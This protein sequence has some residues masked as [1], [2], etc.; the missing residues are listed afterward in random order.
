MEKEPSPATPEDDVS[1]FKKRKHTNLSASINDLQSPEYRVLE[2]A[3]TIKDLSE[4]TLNLSNSSF[5]L[6]SISNNFLCESMD[7]IFWIL[8]TK[9]SEVELKKNKMQVFYLVDYTW[10]YQIKS[11]LEQEQE[12]N[13][14]NLPSE[15]SSAKDYNSNKLNFFKEIKIH[16]TI[17]IL[18]SL[19]SNGITKG[20][21][22]GMIHSSIWNLL[23]NCFEAPKLSFKQQVSISKLNNSYKVTLGELE[24]F[25]Y[26]KNKHS[27]IEIYEKD[28]IKTSW[29]S[30]LE[31]YL[32]NNDFD[33]KS[34]TSYEESK[35]SLFHQTLTNSFEF[36][37]VSE[38]RYG[39]GYTEKS[40]RSNDLENISI[41]TKDFCNDN[42]NQVDTSSNNLFD[43]NDD[44]TK[45]LKQKLNMT[46]DVD[47]IQFNQ[48]HND[49]QLNFN[50]STNSKSAK[51]THVLEISDISSSST[52]KVS[53]EIDFNF[54]SNDIT[55]V[56]HLSA[57]FDLNSVDNSVQEDSVNNGFN[58]VEFTSLL[59][60]IESK[61]SK[62][63]QVN[64]INTDLDNTS[65]RV[66]PG[67]CGLVNLGNTCYMNSALQCLS[68]TWELTD[69]FLSD[70][71][72]TQINRGNPL[73]MKGRFAEEY[74]VFL[75]NLWG[76]NKGV[77][78]PRNF[79]NTIGKFLRQFAGYQQQ[80]APE[81]LSLFLDGL[82]E[83]LN[84]IIDKPYIK[85]PD[86]NSRPDAEVSNE[87]W[88]AYKKRNDSVIVDLFQ[89]QLKSSLTCLKC[90]KNSTTFD[91]FMYMTLLLPADHR[92]DI[93][94][95]FV[96]A[97]V[98]HRPIKVSS[99]TYN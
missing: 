66:L 82:H 67:L 11:H 53:Q 23:G 96:P 54:L 49:I 22:L 65:K 37:S 18:H 70:V 58:S 69:Y 55:P 15:Y 40:T 92:F 34:A 93:S 57:Q 90:N 78:T 91:P 1:R 3:T 21:K 39:L 80:D 19:L 50:N 31:Y 85:L 63:L 79:K 84:I 94:V 88:D 8:K 61:N 5:N 46:A 87:Q 89:G 13:L 30:L 73:G 12:C 14:L 38:A 28:H 9:L 25:T 62:S 27:L 16:E 56:S 42:S 59:G 75:K 81:F 35:L 60:E 99:Y 29:L 10:L 32:K 48:P 47:Y 51:S 44:L 97:D 76:I 26:P 24:I 43:H 45:E 72:L 86:S 98:T 52:P 4:N 71:F 83:D 74:S 6:S 64:S 20:I 7:I 36:D 33:N 77:Y 2:N 41:I 68:N 17:A 95:I